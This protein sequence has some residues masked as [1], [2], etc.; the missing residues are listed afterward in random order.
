MAHWKWSLA[1]EDHSQRGRSEEQTR[2]WSEPGKTSL[3][4][5]VCG[6]SQ[7]GEGKL[8]TSRIREGELGACKSI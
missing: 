6:E 8:V 4:E 1:P 2:G 7:V 5:K 3:W